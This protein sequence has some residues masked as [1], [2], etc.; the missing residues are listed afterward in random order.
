VLLLTEATLTESQEKK[1][2]PATSYEPGME[3]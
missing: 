2:K 1:E 3:G